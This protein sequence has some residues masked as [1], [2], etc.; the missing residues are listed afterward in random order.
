MFAFRLSGNIDRWDYS[1]SYF[2]G[3]DDV[4]IARKLVINPSFSTPPELQMSFPKMQVA[5]IDIATDLSG[6][7]LW[8]E[9][10]VFWP[11]EVPLTTVV[12][13]IE[14]RQRQLEDK[15]Y[16]KFTIGGDYTLSNGLYLNTQ[17]MHGFF[18][19]RG[20]GSLNDYFVMQLEKDYFNEDLL[21]TLGNSLEVNDWNAL[22]YSL[23]PELTYQAIDNFE[24]GVGAFLV[25]G[26]EGTL[27][28]SW[29]ELDQIFLRFRVDF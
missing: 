3:Y 4:P 5:G 9:A 22:G 29:N 23:S 12:D 8:A 14:T 11:E 15:P 26:E 25:W 20:S 19:E 10:G 2:N 18:T 13:N 16:L 1:L 27:F 6:F 17:W 24:A 21:V 7:G 28:N